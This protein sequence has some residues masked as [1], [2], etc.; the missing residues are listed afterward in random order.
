MNLGAL[1]HL[2]KKYDEASIA[3]EQALRLQPNNQ[4][5]KDNMK[6]LDRLKAKKTSL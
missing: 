1:Y 4:M 2:V 6:K 3:Y 5:L